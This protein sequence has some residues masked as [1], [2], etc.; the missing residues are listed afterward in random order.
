MRC[1]TKPRPGRHGRW[2]AVSTRSNAVVLCAVIAAR[3]A[4]GMSELMDP[5]RN[6]VPSPCIGLCSLDSQG[7]CRGCWRTGGEIGSWMRMNDSERR[8]LME[9]VLPERASDATA[10]A[11]RL[12]GRERL[13]QA[14]LP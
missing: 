13:Q 7:Y 8:R 14:L 4:S 1:R 6:A 2:R 5:P 12:A 11:A 9:Q 10:F 3:Y